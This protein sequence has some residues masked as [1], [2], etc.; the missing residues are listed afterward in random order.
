MSL[1]VVLVFTIEIFF[2][3]SFGYKD[4]RSL[5]KNNVVQNQ[6]L[7][8]PLYL[9]PPHQLMLLVTHVIRLMLMITYVLRLSYG[10]VQLL[11]PFWCWLFLTTLNMNRNSL[12]TT[13]YALV[14][15]VTSSNT[16][17]QKGSSLR[18]APFL[19]LN[20]TTSSTVKKSLYIKQLL[21]F[22]TL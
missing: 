21:I 6:I 20:S 10:A 9:S 4:A 5:H 18:V 2:D 13:Q 3:W 14:F 8:F 22:R 19:G 11:L 17:R 7:V 16:S 12:H 15:F 1:T